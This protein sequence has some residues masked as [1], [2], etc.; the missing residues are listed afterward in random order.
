[1][2]AVSAVHTLSPPPP[3]KQVISLLI[4]CIPLCKPVLHIFFLSS[5]FPELFQQS[6]RCSTVDSLSSPLAPPPVTTNLTSCQSNRPSPGF[7]CILV[8]PLSP[9]IDLF[10]HFRHW[11]RVKNLFPWHFDTQIS[12]WLLNTVIKT[13]RIKIRRPATTV[14]SFK[15]CQ[16]ETWIKI[17]LLLALA[18]FEI[19][20]RNIIGVVSNRELQ[21]THWTPGSPPGSATH[22][23]SFF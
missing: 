8:S 17:I 23:R 13:R 2:V 9:L 1:M 4:L 22:V 16:N 12:T 15:S 3:L 21:L 20:I 18:C 6:K 11:A 10:T 19:L 5:S 14:C 7:V